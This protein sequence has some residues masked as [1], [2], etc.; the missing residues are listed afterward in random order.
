MQQDLSIMPFLRAMLRA[1]YAAGPALWRFV[2][3]LAWM[4]VIG[5]G[6][7]ATLLLVVRMVLFPNIERYRDT[8]TSA[9]AEKVRQPVEIDTLSTGWNGWN[10]KLVINGFRMGARS[11]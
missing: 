9:I 5:V 4:V 2:M 6:L 3:A 7:F 1:P 11:P 10:P 8:I